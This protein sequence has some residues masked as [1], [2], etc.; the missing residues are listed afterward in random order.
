[1][2]PSRKSSAMQARRSWGRA[3]ARSSRTACDQYVRMHNWNQ[4]TVPHR[5]GGVSGRSNVRFESHRPSP[6]AG[7][8]FLGACVRALK[9]GGLLLANLFNNDVGSHARLRFAAFAEQ[10]WWVVPWV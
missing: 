2:F 8:V 3:C 5:R 4:Q 9:P 10:V 1:M 6:T 7:A